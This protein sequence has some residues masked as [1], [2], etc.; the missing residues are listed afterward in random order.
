M[1]AG[2]DGGG[3]VQGLKD[4]YRTMHGE[5]L[6]SGRDD[7]ILTYFRSYLDRTRRV[8]DLA[9]TLAGDPGGALTAAKRKEEAYWI[10]EKTRL[11]EGEYPWLRLIGMSGRCGPDVTGP[12]ELPGPGVR[13][14]A[15][16]LIRDRVYL[17]DS[18]LWKLGQD[19]G[20]A[21][22]SDEKGDSGAPDAG[23]EPDG[24]AGTAPDAGG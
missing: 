19:S 21:G 3:R 13:D 14:R 20:A 22:L 9:E 23:A 1:M 18:M 6:E 7:I 10:L 24:A 4:S 2:K 15:Y 8:L 11:M 17:L 5:R 12:S 16:A